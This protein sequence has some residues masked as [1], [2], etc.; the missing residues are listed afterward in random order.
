MSLR[1]SANATSCGDAHCPPPPPNSLRALACLQFLPK[2]GSCT[3]IFR[4]A[5]LH[6]S[7][8]P[9]HP[10]QCTSDFRRTALLMTHLVFANIPFSLPNAT[11]LLRK[12]FCL[13]VRFLCV[14]VRVRTLLLFIKY[15]VS[16]HRSARWWLS[17]FFSFPGKR[18]ICTALQPFNSTS[19]VSWQ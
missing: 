1:C 9:R 13:M 17:F 15:G 11:P 10:P 3:S 2:G 8:Q 7:F 4:S 18:T 5:I 19:P 16:S 6:I 12:K 14:C